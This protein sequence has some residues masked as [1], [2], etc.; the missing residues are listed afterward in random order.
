MKSKPFTNAF[1]IFLTILLLAVGVSALLSLFALSP[2]IHGFIVIAITK[3]LADVATLVL[4]RGEQKY[5][6]FEDYLR[7]TF[8]FFAVMAV[9]VL[10]ISQITRYIGGYVWFPLLAA[11]G[12]AI[13]R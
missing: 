10:A 6:F 8:L 13:W 11:A 4:R 12:V 7:E 1:I 3:I 5:L 2:L 9:C